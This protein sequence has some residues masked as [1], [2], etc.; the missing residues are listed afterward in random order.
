MAVVSADVDQPIIVVGGRSVV[1]MSAVDGA[2]RR[3]RAMWVMPH[4]T[5]DF[6][7]TRPHL[8]A[9]LDSVFVQ[10]DRAWELVIVDDRSDDPAAITHLGRLADR[11]ADRVHVITRPDNRGAGVARNVGIKHAAMRGSPFVLFLDADDLAHPD[12]LTAVRDEFASRSTPGVV[13]S[14][15]DVVDPEGRNVPLDEMTGSIAEVIEAHR[16]GPP[17]G[18]E[19]WIPIGTETG[20]V[21]HTSSTAVR[22]GVAVAHPF[23]PERVSEDAHTWF[24]YSA[25]GARFAYLDAPLSAYR[26]TTDAAGSS[27]RSREGGKRGFY[28]SKARVDAD[29]F[30]RAIDLALER[31]AIDPGD[32][33]GLW[34]GFRVRLAATL[35]REGQYTLAIEQLA[36]ARS[37]STT[38][39]D[40]RLGE[41]DWDESAWERGAAA[42]PDAPC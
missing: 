32:V 8:E 26:A 9:A 16:S 41:Q 23:P 35:A 12:R 19:V 27:S 37:I 13:Y 25:G 21:N 36:A 4:W 29:G 20:Y 17:V 15:F 39:T 24:R 14:T 10:T 42:E 38:A 1:V 33:T 5:D 22:T 31:G 3:A 34:V 30:R 2:Q 11:W 18:S 7:R 28:A 40:R 6:G